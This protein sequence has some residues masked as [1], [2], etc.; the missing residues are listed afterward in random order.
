MVEK[1]MMDKVERSPIETHIR[2]LRERQMKS[3]HGPKAY[4]GKPNMLFRDSDRDGV[5]N[6]FDC[7]PFNRRKQDVIIPPSGNNPVQ[8]MY[9]RQEYNRQQRQYQ[10]WLKEQQ[11]LEEA[12]LRELQRLSNVQVIDRTVTVERSSNPNDFVV[13]GNRVVS[14]SSPEGK[15]Y[16]KT[17]VDKANSDK[18]IAKPTKTSTIYG[19]GDPNTV[20]FVP[21]KTPKQSLGSKIVKAI[22]KTF[23]K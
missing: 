23:G 14:K 1:W 9:A 22:G 19:P 17:V 10:E 12:R 8:E 21:I 11:K 13:V 2:S 18:A 7:K 4:Y 6:V 15:T 16:M 20:R 5:S 3:F